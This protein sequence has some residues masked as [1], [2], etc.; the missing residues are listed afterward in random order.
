MQI[1]CH[2]TRAFTF[3]PISR[4][5][6]SQ[7]C[8]LSQIMHLSLPKKPFVTRKHLSPYRDLF[9]IN[10]C[11]FVKMRTRNTIQVEFVVSFAGACHRARVRLEKKTTKKTSHVFTGAFL[12]SCDPIGPRGALLLSASP[13]NRRSAYLHVF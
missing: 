13:Q 4:C 11:S 2:E 6:P 3:S 8:V 7:L 1:D 12:S 5:V 9:A 10:F